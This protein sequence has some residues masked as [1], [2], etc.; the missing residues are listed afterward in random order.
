[1]AA[2]PI[3]PMTAAPAVTTDD[4]VEEAVFVAVPLLALLVVVVTAAAVV[5]VAAEVVVEISVEVSV[6]DS[7]DVDVDTA[8]DVEVV[9]VPAAEEELLLPLV[10][11]LAQNCLVAGRTVPVATSMPH[12]STTHPVAA[13]VR[14]SMFLHTQG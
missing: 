10:S 1:M 9:S 3:D 5:V 6:D 2:E 13:A 11:T 8:V 12:L 4:G 14:V 7:T